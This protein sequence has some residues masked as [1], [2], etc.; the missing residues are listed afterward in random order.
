[1]PLY[2]P[3]ALVIEA[4][5]LALVRRPL[6]F[7]PFAGLAAG[8]IGFAAEWPWVNAVFAIDWNSALLP[9]GPL[10]A[11]A[12]GAAAGA[13]GALF[14]LALRRELP[15]PGLARGLA[16][17]S[18]AVV[19]GCFGFGLADRTPDGGSA[20]VT[21]ADMTPGPD[22]EVLATV[23]FD[24]PALADGASWVRDIA[25]QGG[26]LVGSQ[27][28]RIG[29][30]LYRSRQPLPVHDDWK[31]AI[32]MHNGHT[33][34]AVELYAPAD[35]AIPAPG[36]AAPAA[37][38]RDLQP[39]RVLLQ[40][41]RKRDVPSWLFT[42]GVLAVLVLILAF[43]TLLGFGLG[44]YAR[45]PRRAEPGAQPTPGRPRLPATIRGARI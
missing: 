3:E 23:R 31:A 44:R 36:V 22:R 39:D 26:G 34:L 41:E 42:A 6:L 33:L 15:R 21:L 18:L 27:M 45:G 43:L 20:H 14:G 4:A 9:E 11:A 29:D 28:E 8:A 38:T 12:A 32:R 13:I 7:G 16:A 10:V 35:P 17:A 24:P 1:M 30:G 37:F 5:A 19:I 2:V 40:K 25:W